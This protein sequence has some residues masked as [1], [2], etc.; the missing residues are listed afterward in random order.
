AA[1]PER[2]PPR[3][4][5]GSLAGRG[6]GWGGG[7]IKPARNLTPL[8]NPSP[9]GGEGP[10]TSPPSLL[11]KATRRHASPYLPHQT[12]T[13][14]TKTPPTLA[15]KRCSVKRLDYCSVAGSAASGAGSSAGAWDSSPLMPSSSSSNISTEFAGISG[16]GLCSP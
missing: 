15:G 7:G 1:P 13:P 14:Q 8:P 3:A 5:P 12:H 9:T 16:L 2:R 10:S 4:D 6:Y 11:A